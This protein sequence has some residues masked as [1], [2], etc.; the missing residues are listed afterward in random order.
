MSI[1]RRAAIAVAGWATLET[2]LARARQPDRFFTPREMELLD[3]VSE[4]ILPADQHSPGA[5]AAGVSEYIHLIAANSPPKDQQRWRSRVQA[6][7]QYAE[8][9]QGKPFQTLGPAQRKAVLAS[10]APEESHPQTEAGHFFADLKQITVFAYYTSR[11]GLLDELEYK[12][13]QA[14]SAFPACAQPIKGHA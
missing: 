14:M 10:L 5:R 9:S 8:K 12:G 11:I 3:L 13:N 2:R 1:D 7:A 4:M 6:F